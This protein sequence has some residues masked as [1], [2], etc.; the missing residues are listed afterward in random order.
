MEGL[1][2]LRQVIFV[3]Q[4][5]LAAFKQEMMYAAHHLNGPTFAHA[6]VT[7]KELVAALTEA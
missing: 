5:P 2:F 1:S 7:T 6:I 3:A 4:R